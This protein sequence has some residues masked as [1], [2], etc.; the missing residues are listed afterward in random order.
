M[1]AGPD[2]FRPLEHHVFEEVRESGAPLPFVLRPDRIA[3]S[4]RVNGSVMVFY[5]DDPK[6]VVEA[7]I[8]EFNGYDLFG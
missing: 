8:A 3:H 5:K 6:S 4:D 1:L 2:L 7:R